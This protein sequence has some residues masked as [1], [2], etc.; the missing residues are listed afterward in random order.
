MKMKNFIYGFLLTLLFVFA[1]QAQKNC[2][3]YEPEN[4]TL[5][6]KLSRLSLLNA[7]KQKETIYV[8]KLKLPVCVNADAENEFNLQQN[9]VGDIQLV[10]DAETYR[11]SRLL[12]NK[13]VVVSGTLFGEHTQHHF[14]KVLLTVARIKRQ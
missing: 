1:A 8:L 5:S 3:T 2:L 4:V 6:G 10:F 12:V 11:S 13:T 9:K 7:S 14:T